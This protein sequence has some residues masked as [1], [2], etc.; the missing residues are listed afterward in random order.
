MSLG[1]LYVFLGELSVQV[2]CPFFNWVACLLKME[3]C[4]ALI[5]TIRLA[6]IFLLYLII[7]SAL[8]IILFKYFWVKMT[9]EIEGNV[10]TK[11]ISQGRKVFNKRGVNSIKCDRLQVKCWLGTVLCGESS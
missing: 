9:E 3:S 6:F 7:S 10:E 4:D 8:H 5:Y 1:P 11:K 2:L